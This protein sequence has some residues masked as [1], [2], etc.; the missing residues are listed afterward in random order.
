LSWADYNKDGVDGHQFSYQILGRLDGLN[1]QENGA[2]QGEATGA[3]LATAQ[4]QIAAGLTNADGLT[5][6]EIASNL[7]AAALANAS[8][9]AG[10]TQPV[11][12]GLPGP[13]TQIS[14][15]EAQIQG[16]LDADIAGFDLGAA[17]D[18]L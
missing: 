14:D 18:V 13:S 5:Q 16:G 8:K 11:F 4:Q 2:L 6:A 10:V 15:A 3:P 1:E 7:R 9:A 17:L 12:S